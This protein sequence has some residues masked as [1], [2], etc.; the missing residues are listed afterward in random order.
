MMLLR[1]W[2]MARCGETRSGQERS[3]RGPGKGFCLFYIFHSLVNFWFYP[4][5]NEEF[6]IWFKPMRLT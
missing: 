1:N 2:R 6:V 4:K 5:S 3:G